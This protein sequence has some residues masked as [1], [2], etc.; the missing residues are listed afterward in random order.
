MKRCVEENM[1]KYRREICPD[2]IVLGHAYIF[3]YRR[4]RYWLTP[5]PER[6]RIYQ[7]EEHTDASGFRSWKLYFIACKT[8]YDQYHRDDINTI[9]VFENKCIDD[10]F[11]MKLPAF[12]DIIYNGGK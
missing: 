11:I 12:E 1:R 3:D 4:T 10:G 8:V 2:S 7:V 9:T 6:I 5:K